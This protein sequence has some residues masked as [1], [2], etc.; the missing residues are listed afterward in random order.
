MVA[1]VSHLEGSTGKGI[2]ELSLGTAGSF[3]QGREAGFA[4][5]HFCKSLC[6]KNYFLFPAEFFVRAMSLA[7]GSIPQWPVSAAVLG[8]EQSFL[9]PTKAGGASLFSPQRPEGL[10]MSHSDSEWWLHSSCAE[11]CLGAMQFLSKERSFGGFLL[12]QSLPPAPHSHWGIMVWSIHCTFLMSQMQRAQDF[13]F[14][15]IFI[16]HCGR[17]WMRSWDVSAHELCLQ[18]WL[19]FSTAVLHRSPGSRRLSLCWELNK[20]SR[21]TIQYF[22]SVRVSTLRSAAGGWHAGTQGA[23][24]SQCYIPVVIFQSEGW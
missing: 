6:C 11:G 20:H 3:L 17:F 24:S 4:T 16:L 13:L 23:S 15:P 12:S 8:A 9:C 19:Q 7:E 10:F 18:N 14:F 2:S 1:G 5:L 21:K 22:W